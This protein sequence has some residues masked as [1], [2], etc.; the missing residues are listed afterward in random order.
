MRNIILIVCFLHA[1]LGYTQENGDLYLEKAQLFLDNENDSVLIYSKKAKT[2]FSKKNNPLGIVK[3]IEMEGFYH[4]YIKN[5][6]DEAQKKFLE[7]L[8]LCD[9]YKLNYHKNIY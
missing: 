8:K 1:L 2:T 7:C 9:Q 6:Y 5:N 4:L 3:S